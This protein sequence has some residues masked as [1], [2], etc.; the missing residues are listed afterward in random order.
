MGGALIQSDWSCKKWK[1]GCTERHHGCAHKEARPCK[2]TTGR[3]PSVSQ[4]E[5]PQRRLKMLTPWS[6][7]SGLQNYA[8]IN[9]C[10]IGHWSCDILW[11]PSRWKL[12][13]LTTWFLG[14]FLLFPLH[15]LL[16]QKSLA[17][18]FLHMHSLLLI[19]LFPLCTESHNLPV[20]EERVSL[21]VLILKIKIYDLSP[22]GITAL[23]I[24]M[25]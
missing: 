8:E 9:L 13:N 11:Q 3:R 18:H 2:D 15:N 12:S 23:M 14:S 19:L 25:E 20:M 22:S 17:F 7:T 10:C 4:G 24:A 5:G 16:G 21:S 1:L 6:W